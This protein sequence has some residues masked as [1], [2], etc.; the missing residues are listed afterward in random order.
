MKITKMNNKNIWRETAV[1]HS[2]VLH[3]VILDISFKLISNI[4]LAIANKITPIFVLFGKEIF[5]SI[6]VVL[7]FYGLFE[8]ALLFILARRKIVFITASG[9]REIA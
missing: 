1:K 6:E 3:T 7:F 5:S 8:I 9:E 2:H 4:K